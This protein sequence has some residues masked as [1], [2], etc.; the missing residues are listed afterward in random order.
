MHKCIC[1]CVCACAKP[2]LKGP[3]QKG[4]NQA[5]ELQEPS[6]GDS[7][8]PKTGASPVPTPNSLCTLQHSL[9]VEHQVS[10][11]LSKQES[12]LSMLVACEAAQKC[13]NGGGGGHSCLWSILWCWHLG[14]L[15]CLSVA[16]MRRI[17]AP[18]KDSNLCLG[19]ME[20][21]VIVSLFLAWV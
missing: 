14:H 8:T 1:K 11:E 6:A 13:R 18:R 2:S 21:Q 16:N 4:Y 20:I 5:N 10:P 7:N 19:F 3:L 12:L 9:M 15:G 17:T